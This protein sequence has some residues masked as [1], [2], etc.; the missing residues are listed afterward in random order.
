MR[1]PCK[2]QTNILWCGFK[3]KLD[4][5]IL[6][7][8]I[9]KIFLELLL[10]YIHFSK[11]WNMKA[12]VFCQKKV[13]LRTLQKTGFCP[14]LRTYQDFEEKNVFWYHFGKIIFCHY[15]RIYQHF[16]EKDV[17]CWVLFFSISHIIACFF[18]TSLSIFTCIS[19]F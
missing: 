2:Y 15:L 4:L 16:E 13:F 8:T 18:D 9:F 6:K 3:L 12:I 7:W 17:F 10:T 5:F 11:V 19:L 1:R 14:Y